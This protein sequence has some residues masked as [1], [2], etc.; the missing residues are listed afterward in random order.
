MAKARVVP[1][2]IDVNVKSFEGLQLMGAMENQ[3]REVNSQPFSNGL[4][5]RNVIVPATG[6]KRVFHNLKRIP[7]GYIITKSLVAGGIYQFASDEA[8]ITFANPS[9]GNVTI[10]V[11]VF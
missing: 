2:T 4:W 1:K 5:I 6:T 7:S 3:R 9:V 10:D 8:S 11:W